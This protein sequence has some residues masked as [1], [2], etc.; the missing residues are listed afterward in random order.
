MTRKQD[1]WA[2]VLDWN[3]KCHVGIIL[4]IYGNR[5]QHAMKQETKLST[6]S[7]RRREQE[8]KGKQRYFVLDT[9]LK[10]ERKTRKRARTMSKEEVTT[11][12]CPKRTLFSTTVH[13]SSMRGALLSSLKTF[14][15]RRSI[16]IGKRS[17][18]I[19]FF[20]A[21]FITFDMRLGVSIHILEEGIFFDDDS[22]GGFK[23]AND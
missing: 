11:A 15:K 7:A 6:G 17:I 4:K 2:S 13:M 5:R 20:A 1:E 23:I 22:F 8:E 14:L 9:S 12:K 3:N 16:G 21:F 18:L 10:A 19:N